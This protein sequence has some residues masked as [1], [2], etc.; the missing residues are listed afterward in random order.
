MDVTQQGIIALLKSAVTAQALPLPEGFDI[1]AVLPLV[2]KHHMVSLIYDGAVR[3]GVSLN[4]PAMQEMFKGYCRAVQVN[5]AQMAQYH[6]ICKAFDEAQID[7][8][9]LK[10]CLMKARYPKPELRLMGDADILIRMEQYDKI[11]PIMLSLGFEEQGESD[12]E[13]HW[14]SAGLHVELHKRL[15]PSYNEDFHAYF[16]DGWQLAKV[17]EGTRYAMTPEDEMVYLFTHF[18]KH[19]RDGGIGC[20]YVV[21]LWVYRLAHPNLDEKK[22][23]AVLE[24]LYLLDFYQNI[25]CLMEFWFCG[26][27]SNAKLEHIT[28]YVFASGSWGGVAER[29]LGEAIR[30]SVRWNMGIKLAYLRRALFPSVITLK[31]KYKVL[32]KAP[33]LLPVVWIIR[34]FYKV[35]FEPKSLKQQKKNLEVMNDKAVKEHNKALEYVGLG[36]HF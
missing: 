29:T 16:G 6:K 24:K 31:G 8:M 15:V 19:Y 18:A 7:Y 36:Y 1:E 26:G 2:R 4:T 20:R 5:E 23:E 34:P 27:K 10:G 12:H 32:R 21:D 33:W 28:E 9:P 14:D 22:I 25:L 35:L 17:K 30:S 3:C 13:L 11:R